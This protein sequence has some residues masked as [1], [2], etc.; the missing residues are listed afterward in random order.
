MHIRVRGQTAQLIR[1]QYDQ[2]TKKGKNTV[3][4]GVKLTKP[5]LT[6]DLKKL[7]TPEE[8]AAFDVWL[9]TH[10][11]T[12]SLQR[13]L[14]ALTLSERMAEAGKWFSANKDNEAARTMAARIMRE[15]QTLRKTLNS[16]G[17][18]D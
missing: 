9:A 1:T 2:E 18:L 14:S 16:N 5:E 8:I 6:A 12:I 17:L 13:H 3:L 4:G 11:Q 10:Q 7:L 15:W